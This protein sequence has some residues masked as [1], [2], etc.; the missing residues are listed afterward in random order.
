MLSSVLFI[1]LDKIIVIAGA[2]AT[3]KSQLAHQ[4]AY[5][6][7]GVILNADSL[8]VYSSLEILTDQPSLEDQK[9]IPHRLYGFVEPAQTFDVGSW[10][11]LVTLEIKSAQQNNLIPIVVG[12]TGFYLK[13]LMEGISYCPPIDPSIRKDLESR[14]DSL[15]SDL[16]TKDPSLASKLQPNDHQRILRALEVYY[17]TGKPLSYWQSQKPDPSPY[18]FEKILVSRSTEETNQRIE[19]RIEAMFQ[20]D[21]IEEARQALQQNPSETALKAIGLRELQGYFQNQY[22][23]EEAKELMIVHTR[24][25]A[26]RQRTWFR[27]Q[28]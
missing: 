14:E 3:G 7:G 15:Y 21:V 19:S 13:S 1:A 24:Q 9:A 18:E 17:G 22:S 26:K 4:I 5:E 23:L 8:Q 28:F 27:H 20:R 12:G 25:Y 16:Q 10:L 11:N 2:T 6:K